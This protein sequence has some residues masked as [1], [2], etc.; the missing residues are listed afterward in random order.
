M[1]GSAAD[2]VRFTPYHIRAFHENER[3]VIYF[4]HHLQDEVAR[5]FV[6]M[7]VLQTDI[8]RQDVSLYS[9]LLL[10]SNNALQ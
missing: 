5:M 10:L 1:E 3:A 8:T 2:T 7:T 4:P 6:L 9:L